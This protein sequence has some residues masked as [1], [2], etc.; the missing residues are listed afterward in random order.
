MDD[1]IGLLIGLFVLLI[2]FLIG[3]LYFGGGPDAE[4]ACAETCSPFISKII[5][6]ECY[7]KTLEGD[8]H[9]GRIEE[10]P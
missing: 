4:K 10:S 1:T 3:L 9:L 2:G 5:D 7:C 6:G 8:W